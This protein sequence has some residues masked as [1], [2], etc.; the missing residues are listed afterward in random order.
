MA[1]FND[2]EVIKTIENYFYLEW[3]FTPDSGQ[4]EA[5][6]KFFILWSQ[7]PESGY[8]EVLDS[9]G[10]PIEV[11]PNQ[12]FFTHEFRQYNF[13]IQRYYKVKAVAQFGANDETI[14]DYT[15]VGIFRDGPT[16][17]IWRNELIR[18]KT[19]CGEPAHIIKRHTFGARC[20]E[21]YDEYR[22][23]RKYGHCPVCNGTTFLY[24]W[25]Q[26]I[27]IQ[28]DTDAD[29]S[30]SVSNKNFEDI[31]DD[32]VFRMTNYPL[33]RPG[34]LI[35]LDDNN[36]RLEV[37]GVQRTKLP[38]RATPNAVGPEDD[39]NPGVK[40]MS[41]Q[42]YYLSQ[43]ISV[44][45]YVT[46]DDE[47]FIDIANIP[48][49]P[50]E[51]Q[52]NGDYCPPSFLTVDPPLELT[53]RHLTF[54]YNHNDF[55]V[56]SENEL[57]LIGG[58]S[59]GADFK[60]TLPAG[61]DITTNFHAVIAESGEVYYAN[62]NDPSHLNRV[63]GVGVTTGNTGDD[64]DVMFAGIIFN[65]AWNWDESKKIF[66][67]SSGALTQTVQP[68]GFYQ[69]VGYAVDAQT[70]RVEISEPVIRVA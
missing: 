53:G 50:N 9:M 47:Y 40:Q 42:N 6:Y 52:P 69:F 46:S 32:R 68:N 5:D 45:E 55:R 3:M 22:G 21:C 29:P 44:K 1:E 35:V 17:V 64:I 13:N 26:P 54:L 37:I 51:D 27:P 31:Y 49:I 2:L 12:N 56:N 61:E 4:L 19:Y 65:G 60:I 66:F 11:P 20:P 38:L 57:E 63:L 10:D 36:K 34:D 16:N 33:V 59:G 18:V 28:I 23:T 41:R 58:G 25:Y 39:Q 67:D 24:G 62:Y 48:E 30:K 8:Q 15:Y 70:I 7:D 43:L 14:S